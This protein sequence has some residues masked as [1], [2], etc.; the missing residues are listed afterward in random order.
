[1]SAEVYR[2]LL[3][4]ADSDDVK[5]GRDWYSAAHNRVLALASESGYT[6]EQVA[7]VTAVLSPMVEWNLNRK[8][9]ERFCK[10]KGKA[11]GI[12]GFTRNRE[13]AKNILACKD[14]AAVEEYVRGPKVNPFYHTLLDPSYPVATIDT[15]MIAA[16]YKGVAYRDD[17]KI[18]SDSP[19]R[20]EPLRK[21]LQ[22]IATEKGWTVSEVQAVIWLTFKRLNGPYANQ[23]KL[24]K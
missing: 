14:S 15:Q 24:F 19:K 12:P 21:A 7:G 6:P 17:L 23:L 13:K 2:E 4:K 16:F 1:M 5:Q 22:Q 8:T 3:S 20:Q 9:A 10:S 18:I 11:R